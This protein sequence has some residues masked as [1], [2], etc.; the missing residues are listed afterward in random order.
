MYYYSVN[1]QQAGPVSEEQLRQ[2]VTTGSLKAD[3]LVWREG[4]GEWQ[5]F[6]TA[7]GG[8][9]TPVVQCSVCKQVF[10]PDQT[11]QYGG[12]SV[13]AN[14][15]PRFVQGLKEGVGGPDQN[16]TLYAIALNQRKALGC[17][18]LLILGNVARFAALAT[19]PAVAVGLSLATFAVMIFS[20]VYVY[21]LAKALGS[22]ALLYAIA[23]LVP[24]LGLLMLLM[25]VSRATATLKKAGI[26]VG[27]MGVSKADL[28]RLRV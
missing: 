19:V 21:R 11:I 25:I 7:L 27:L 23:M 28:E 16:A 20:I 10:P 1:G 13:C 15:K 18:G 9:A 3:T 8:V 12:V 5:P 4:M 24:C 22:P 2:M 6:S 14:C 17:V 26:K